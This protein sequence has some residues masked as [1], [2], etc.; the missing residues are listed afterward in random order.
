MKSAAAGILAGAALVAVIPSLPSIATSFAILVAGLALSILKRL[1]IPGCIAAGF[2]LASLAGGLALTDR[3]AAELEG[4]DI[5]LEGVVA[6]IPVSGP[7][8]LRFVFEAVATQPGFTVPRRI[9]ISWYGAG[10]LPAAGERWR[11]LVRLRRP[12]GTLNPGGF[13]YERWLLQERIGAIGYV[14]RSARNKRLASADRH[15]LLNY[16]YRLANR[17]E[18]LVAGSPFSGVLK[19]LT[20]GYRGDLSQNQ[21]QVF[22]RTGTGHLLAISGLHIG[23][24]ATLGILLARLFW[25]L[26]ALFFPGRTLASCR[27][28][29]STGGGLLAATAYAALAGFSLPTRRALVM[30]LVVVVL[31]NLRRRSR[32][33]LVFSI[34]L[35]AVLVLQPLAVLSA[36]FWLSF[37][38][39]AGLIAGFSGQI[40]KSG[41]LVMAVRS[42]LLV[43]FAL[44]VPT[45]LIFGAVPLFAPFVNLILV[46]LFAVVIVPVAL[47]STLLLAVSDAAAATGYAVVFALLEVSW[48]ALQALAASG[49][50]I[51][52]AAD[53]PLYAILVAIVGAVFFLLPRGFPGRFAA[54]LLLVPALTWSGIQPEHGQF[55]L[56]VLDVGQGLSA[57]VRTHSRTLVFDAG[58][59]WYGGGDAGTRI[60]A[61]FLRSRGIRG[62]DML[63][64][65]H[66]D[67]DHRG[68]AIGLLGLVPATRILTGPAVDLDGHTTERCHEGPGWEWD[69]IQ[70]RFL[71]PSTLETRGGNDSSCVLQITGRDL[72]ILL[73]GDIERRAESRLLAAGADL[74]SDL[75]VAPHHGSATSSTGR[76]VSAAAARWVIFPAGRNN[77]W[78]FPHPDVRSRWEAAGARTWSTGLA[79]GIDVRFGRKGVLT[80]PIGWRC[81]SR[82]FW[83]FRS[84]RDRGKPSI[85][86]GA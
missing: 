46:P 7:G 68:G 71:N 51:T 78:G 24:A 40:L 47:A 65:S 38:A 80:A 70:F 26:A 45:L 82:R 32:A 53:V 19:A 14:R 33:T 48:P 39:V 52:R 75:V 25:Q 72:S 86:G 28:T 34:A 29:F 8:S 63:V 79:G 1:V 27:K 50:A 21:A 35:V 84:C 58:P 55:E 61:P 83:R 57:V 3:L 12:A 66:G 43:W 9:R 64:I 16:R 76:F 15:S 85:S 13:D 4:R 20:L 74:S 67:N 17:I 22:R 81:Q 54:P 56:T 6:D 5:L 11:L 73:A 37:T 49:A 10:T 69:G 62:I 18:D 59:A 41:R 60:V 36:G 44:L 31:T 77:R 42:Q 23:I 30:L 2:G